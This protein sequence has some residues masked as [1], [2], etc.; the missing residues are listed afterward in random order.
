MLAGLLLKQSANFSVLISP[1]SGKNRLTFG[2]DLV[3]G[4]DSGSLFQFPPSPFHNREF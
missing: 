3:P 4:I 2:G 1:A